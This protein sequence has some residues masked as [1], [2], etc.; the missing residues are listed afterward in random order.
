MLNHSFFAGTLFAFLT[1]SSTLG[2]A[3]FAT[4]RADAAQ[5]FETA[6]SVPLGSSFQ[7]EEIQMDPTAPPQTFILERFSVMN[8]DA[9]IVINGA[10]GKRFLPV[11]NN[12]YYYGRIEGRPQARVYM[13]VL[14]K[15]QIR[16]VITE[17]G[18]FWMIGGG[19][20]SGGPIHGFAVLQ[21]D[22][23]DLAH[24]AE[25]YS[26]DTSFLSDERLPTPNQANITP[27][28]AK[29][30]HSFLGATYHATIA[31]ESDWEY[32][33]RFGNASD[34]TDYA[35][36]LIAY[37]STVYA[38]EIDTSMS[39]GSVSLWETSNDPWVQSSTICGLFEFGRYWN[40]NNTG[41]ERT[42]AHYLSGKNNGGGVAWVGV[43][44]NGPFNQDLGN[45]CLNMT[46]RIDNY[47]G[48]YG[49]SGDLDGNFNINNPNVVWDIV[50]VAHEIGHNF[51]SPHTHCYGNI[52]GNS[53]PVDQCTSGQ[54]GQA[55]CHCGASSLPCA[56]PGAGCGTIMSYC[57]F[58]AGNLSN[59]S[60]TFGTGH[61]HGVAP[62]RVPQR[63]SAAVV[64]AAQ[65]N[66]DCLA[67]SSV[68]LGDIM[69]D[70]PG[71]VSIIDLIPLVN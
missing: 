43:L 4:V 26:C 13:S 51:N 17:P 66:P 36:D 24:A 67:P 23:M 61:P 56:T 48:D 37:S 57:H 16:G 59:I 29:P 20:D 55:G 22:E 71:T 49:Y 44:C 28:P 62:E 46:P 33:N 64:S 12:A 19:E 35:M 69:G 2:H 25:P 52:G 32:Y 6:H 50:V 65:A 7:I 58:Q 39:I 40:D 31:I 53:E 60:M 8:A 1:M 30:G 41:I 3:Q 38:A 70:W 15:G 10:N 27:K 47:G 54:C 5:L 63:M 45:N 34:A 14:Q 9:Q 18:R 21:A 68:T 42:L 11:P